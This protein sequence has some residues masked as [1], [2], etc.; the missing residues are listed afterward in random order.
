MTR[1]VQLLLIAVCIFLTSCASPLVQN[2]LTAMQG[3]PVDEAFGV[4][5][6]PTGKMELGKDTLYHWDMGRGG[7]FFAPSTATSFSNV[8]G[9]PVYTT[10]NFTQ[11][12]PT[13]YAGN[14]KLLVD[15]KGIVK[16]YSFSG[17]E[18]AFE[19]IALK[20][21]RHASR[22]RKEQEAKNLESSDSWVSESTKRK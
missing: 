11:A 12:V 15:A 1:S 2:G 19:F 17:Q 8:G 3:R 16:S 13:S 21:Q 10:T 14:I 4:L 22:V 20:L 7:V 9:T 6:Y 5:G 18:G